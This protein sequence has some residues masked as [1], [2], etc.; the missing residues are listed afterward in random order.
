MLAPPS[1]VPAYILWG[2]AGASLIVG[3]SF[4]FAA[5]SAKSDFDDN[6]TYSKAD[7]VHNRAVIADVA[8]GLGAILAVTG[9]VFFFADDTAEG[10][11]ADHASDQHPARHI[12]KPGAAVAQ[13]HFVPLLS[14]SAGGGFVS[15]RF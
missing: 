2:A 13:V 8:L 15:V 7:S 10:A 3:A 6:P 12:R 4:G 11:G 1:K 5:L 9:T 14:P